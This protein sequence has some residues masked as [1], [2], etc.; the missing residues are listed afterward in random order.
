MTSVKA[1]YCYNNQKPYTTA[2]LVPNAIELKKLTSN[3]E[4]AAKLIEKEIAEYLKGGK[5]EGVFPMRWIP[6]GLAVIE[7]H[8]TEKNGMVNSTM[9]IV[10]HK[11]YETFDN[12]INELYT[13][14]GKKATSPSNLK[15][16]E[17][18]LNS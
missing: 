6:S 12:R 9:K 4:E 11:V 10:K 5:Y 7:E 2:L 3:P 15:V 18:L 17:R 16:L 8:F 14:E 13:P 1:P